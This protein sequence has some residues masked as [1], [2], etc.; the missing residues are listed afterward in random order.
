MA[1]A[2]NRNVIMMVCTECKNKTKSTSKNKKMIQ[3][4]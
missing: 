3:N 4:V 2:V 1:M